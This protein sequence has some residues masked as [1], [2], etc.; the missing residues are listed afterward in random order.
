MLDTI[1][2]F[3]DRVVQTITPV[4]NNIVAALLIIFLGFI[5]GKFLRGFLL[6][7]LQ[8]ARVDET[9]KRVM[10]RKVSV[11]KAIS[12]TT[13]YIIYVVAFVLALNMISATKYVLS[14]LGIIF[15]VVIIISLLISLKDFFPNVMTGLRLRREQRFT[16]GRSLSFRGIRGKI[17]ERTLL[18]IKVVRKNGDVFLLPNKLFRERT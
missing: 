15:L 8:D 18:H 14:T 16:K 2:A 1:I 5:I 13:A 10:K 17:Q 9:G 11:A 3:A 4:L 7:V 12:D 6:K